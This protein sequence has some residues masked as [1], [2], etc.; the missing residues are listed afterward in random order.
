MSTVQRSFIEVLRAADAADRP[1]L[2]VMCEMLGVPPD[3]LGCFLASDRPG[4]PIA[5]ATA[6]RLLTLE[7]EDAEACAVIGR[8]GEAMRVLMRP[9]CYRKLPVAGVLTAVLLSARY[10]GT[11]PMRIFVASGLAVGAEDLTERM[12][13]GDYDRG[14]A[15]ATL[16]EVLD[17]SAAL[18]MLRG[19]VPLPTEQ[20]ARLADGDP[21]AVCAWNRGLPQGPEFRE[22]LECMAAAVAPRAPLPP[23]V[24]VARGFPAY[25]PEPGAQSQWGIWSGRINAEKGDA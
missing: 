2:D 19:V 18:G 13:C 25:K 22:Y 11:W 6:F 14:C 20:A 1:Y 16:R 21:V 12:V 5:S 4:S 10:C 9:E 24:R 15:P 23:L 8:S 17:V 7:D 3:I